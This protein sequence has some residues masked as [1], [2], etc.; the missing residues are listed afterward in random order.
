MRK[1]VAS[2]LGLNEVLQ[3]ETDNKTRDE[4]FSMLNSCTEEL[5]NI[6]KSINKGINEVENMPLIEGVEK[7][8][9]SSF[10]RDS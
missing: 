6:V 9:E 10:L 2:I 5:D 4:V 8:V 1:P 3:Q 7:Q